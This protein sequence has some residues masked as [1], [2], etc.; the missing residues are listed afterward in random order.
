[1]R[2]KL[3]NG[4]TSRL[5]ER[6]IPASALRSA[7][8]PTGDMAFATAVAAFGQK[9]RGDALLGTFNYGDIA[10]LAGKQTDFWRQ[11]FIR[12]TGVAGSV[13]TN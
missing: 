6:V 13:T 4:D 12:L 9:L 3:P 11:E 8:A 7:A 5:I 2:Y 10:S 1:M